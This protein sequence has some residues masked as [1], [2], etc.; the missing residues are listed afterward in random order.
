MP[1]ATSENRWWLLPPPGA[2]LTRMRRFALPL[3]LLL[4]TASPA[5]AQRYDIEVRP[6]SVRLGQ[7][8]R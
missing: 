1:R 8:V 4:V 6:D 2:R 5:V 3:A 7:V